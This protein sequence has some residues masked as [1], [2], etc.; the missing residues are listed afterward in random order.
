[1]LIL[2]GAV[3]CLL[4]IACAN[5]AGLLL[6]RAA[7]RRHELAVRTAIGAPRARI[8]RQ[9]LTESLL[10]ALLGGGLGLL[11]GYGGLAALM[12]FIP[13]NVPRLQNVSLDNRVFFFTA[14]LSIS[15][16]M[17][18]GLIPAWQASRANLAAAFKDAGRSHTAGRGGHG[19]LVTVEVA[20]VAVLLVGAA[21]TLQS[22]RRLLSVETGF[23]P[24]GV[25]TFEVS[26]PQARYSN[27][28]QRT[29]FYEQARSRLGGLPGVSAV[30]AGSNLPLS[31]NESMNFIAVEGAPPVEPGKEPMADDRVITPGYFDAM[32]MRLARGRDFTA[33]DG[34]GKPLAAI[35]NE[36]LARQYFPN[37]D[38]LGRRIKWAL[39]DKEWR[40]IVGVVR[41]VRGF[42]LEAQGRP[43]LYHPNAQYPFNDSM[44]VAVRADASALPW[45]RGA[46]QRELKQLDPTIPVAN[47]RTMAALV[48]RSVAKPRFSALLLGL[49]AGVALLLAVV[50]LY[51]VVAYGVSQR[52]REIGIRMALGAQRQN[53]L[54]LSIGQGMRPALVGVGLGM[55]GAF[56][57]ARLLAG[58]LYEIKPTDPM[59]FG[60]V[61]AGLSIVA[62]VAC[63]IPARRATQV[64]PLAAL[65]GE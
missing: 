42:A 50:G 5:I 36:A 29:Q 38:A 22:F 33:S 8:V 14:L 57:L 45:L 20:L 55:A 1:L 65:R 7:G 31:G 39:D 26:L 48:S 64:D 54:A 47:Y 19:L 46:I 63:Y 18:S 27:G 32:G 24:E 9:L 30:G 49:F 2:L 52:T 17:L 59:T 60:L 37:G 15:T 35:V 4:L 21:L 16:G 10:L 53:V 13:P 6:A 44:Y 41:D 56:A 61:A 34:A 23:R 12:S 11:A 25:A 51:G 3:G 58:Q 28:E 40:T 62:L 43:Q